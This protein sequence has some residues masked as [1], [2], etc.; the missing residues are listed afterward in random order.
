[1]VQ[2]LENDR[3]SKGLI[4]KEWIT[5]R[6]LE[7]QQTRDFAVLR[8]PRWMPSYVPQTYQFRRI[9]IIFP[10]DQA[11]GL[12]SSPVVGEVTLTP[13]GRYVLQI[14]TECKGKFALWQ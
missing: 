4:F 3:R 5:C 1:M 14:G 10:Y 7:P 2:F 12:G 11:A 8:D 9:V 6:P 13:W